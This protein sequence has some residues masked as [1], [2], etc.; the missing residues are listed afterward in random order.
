MENA[1]L[2]SWFLEPIETP[3]K[4]LSWLRSR[5]INRLYQFA[6]PTYSSERL[7]SFVKTAQHFDVDV[8]FLNGE[9]EW[10]LD[11]TGYEMIQYIEWVQI[12]YPNV[13]GIVFDIEPYLLQE[14]KVNP[15]KVMATFVK[16][17]VKVYQETQKAQLEIILCI[18]YFYDLVGFKRELYQSFYESGCG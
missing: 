15:Q 2:F 13:K 6:A 14:Y 12:N 17:M 5:H 3:Q 16:A 1:S 9:P 7:S 4:T 10:A 8:Y 18:P 11:T